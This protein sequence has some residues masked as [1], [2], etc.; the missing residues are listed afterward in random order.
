M[1]TPKESSTPQ[2]GVVHYQVL[3]AFCLAVVLLIQ[4]QDGLLLTNLFGVLIG[5]VG[6]LY[7][8][9]LA[10]IL[11]VALV[12]IAQLTLAHGAHFDYLN[13]IMEPNDVLLCAA[14]LGYVSCHFR[15]QSIWYGV[16]PNDA[17]LRAGSPRRAFPWIRRQA[18]LVHEKRD[19]N[20]ITP[21]ELAWL[22]ATL[23]LWAV[24][25]QVANKL[26]PRQWYLLG[27]PAPFIRILVGLW[28]LV[29]GFAVVRALLSYWK[30]RDRDAAAAQLYLQD[31]MWR[32]TRGEQRRVNRWLAWWKLKQNRDE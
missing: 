7:R 6:L 26:I 14:V 30:H 4:L 24:V 18:P 32:D 29:V 20:Q 11:F 2:V 13:R 9:R 21:R 8:L 23:P 17:R 25:A 19:A 16:L 12:T 22:V 31:I 10:P 28:L 27:F 15:L 3:C 1:N 5:A